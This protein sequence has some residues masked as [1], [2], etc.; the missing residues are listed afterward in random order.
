MTYKKMKIIK[1]DFLLLDFEEKTKK[2]KKI[3]IFKYL[4]R[5]ILAYFFV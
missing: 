3:R 2:T 1:K 5:Y 4:Y